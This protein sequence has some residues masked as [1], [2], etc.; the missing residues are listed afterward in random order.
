MVNK[1]YTNGELESLQRGAIDLVNEDRNELSIASGARAWHGYT[2][3]GADICCVAE[4]A[5]TW[6]GSSPTD[7]FRFKFHGLKEVGVPASK[8]RQ[9]ARAKLLKQDV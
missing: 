8:G 3:N 7:T 6:K 2:E 5:Q 1:T 4:F 9:I